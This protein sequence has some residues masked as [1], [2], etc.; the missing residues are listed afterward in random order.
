MDQGFGQETDWK[1]I[2]ETSLISIIVPVYNVEKYIRECL[3]SILAQSISSFELILVDDGSKDSSGEICEE[4]ASRDK[5]VKVIHKE[6]GGLSSAR[7]AGME[8]AKGEY[9]CFVDSDDGIKTDYLEKLYGAIASCGADL[10]FCDIEATRLGELTEETKALVKE[11][12][13][14]EI[15]DSDVKSWLTDHIS[16]EYVLMVVAW[17]KMYTRALL[18]DLRY[19][20]GRI[21]EDEFMINGLIPRIKKAIFIPD[22][23]YCYRENAEGITGSSNKANARHLDGIDAYADRVKM[24]LDTGDSSFAQRTLVIALY[25][26]ATYYAESIAGIRSASDITDKEERALSTDSWKKMAQASRAKFKEVF[27]K[28]SNVLELK[29][30]MKYEV[31]I[32]SPKLFCKYFL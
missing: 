11:N 12:A 20:E 18:K 22:K 3:D 1:V 28:Y 16:K 5:R 25:K 2:M 8:I 4:Y 7:N 23:L 32:I 29:R 21:H 31:F 19:Q 9:V 24:A 15:S 10:A 30:R 27:T 13:F 6:N 26:T 17:N 14:L